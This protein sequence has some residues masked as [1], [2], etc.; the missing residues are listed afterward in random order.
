MDLANRRPLQLAL[1]A[2]ATQARERVLDVGCGT[3]AA[4]AELCRAGCEAHGIDRSATMVAQARRRLGARVALWN[5]AVDDL[6]DDW[7][8]FD[9]VLAIN[10][11]YFADPAGSMVAAMRRALR[12]G[13][14]LVVYVSERSTMERWRFT[15]AGLHRLYDADELADAIAAGGFARSSISVKDH[16]VARGIRGL[17]ARAER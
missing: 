2:L 6:P 8:G 5:G 16:A 10:V 7:L 13:G 15:R 3:G 17:V 4:L 1:D 9:A 11:L 12:P 14:R